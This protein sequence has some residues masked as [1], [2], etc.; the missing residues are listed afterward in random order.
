MSPT[1][2]SLPETTQ[3]SKERDIHVPAG[4]EPATPV[5]EW[6][7]THAL[8]RAA[9][10]IGKCNY[11]AGFKGLIYKIVLITFLGKVSRE[12]FRYLARQI[13]LKND[14]VLKKRSVSVCRQRCSGIGKW[15]NVYRNACGGTLCWFDNQCLLQGIHCQKNY[16]AEKE[17]VSV[18][19]FSWWWRRIFPPKRW[20]CAS[21]VWNDRQR[22]FCKR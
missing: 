12:G 21:N 14:G 4:F 11:T 18:I 17:R 3:H 19:W 7:Q 8:Y 22:R 1:Q 10:W 16:T 2:R 5:N 15:V 13:R 6:P 9:T 20:I